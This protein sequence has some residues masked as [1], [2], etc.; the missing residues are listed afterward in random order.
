M[1]QFNLMKGSKTTANARYLDSLPV[2]M[3]PTPHEPKPHP[4][5]FDHSRVLLITTT[6]TV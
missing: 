4:G 3:V 1:P 5:I 2:N 6:V